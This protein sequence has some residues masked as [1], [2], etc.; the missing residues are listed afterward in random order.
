MSSMQNPY[1]SPQTFDAPFKAQ[2]VEPAGLWRK[3]NLLVMHKSATLPPKCVKSNV[4]TKRTLK[5]SLTWHH[6]AVFI[7]VLFNLL[8]YL[9]LAMVLSKRATI[10]IGLS[11]EWFAK[12]RRTIMIGW[13]TVLA[14]VALF[15]AGIALM[16]SNDSAGG[17]MMLGAFV[18]FLGGAIYGLIA[19]RL[20]TPTRITDDY[21]WLKGVHP[22]YL[23]S[24]PDW[25]YHP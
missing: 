18:L 9:V 2:A 13:G 7:A 5:R 4:P 12:R 17:F 8:I 21:V 11:D 6:P 19:A 23:A 20:V 15:I 22:D 24:L 10:Y 25:P 1:Q 16:D 14:S 3:D